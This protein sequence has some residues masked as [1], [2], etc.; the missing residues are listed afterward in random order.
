MKTA[1]LCDAHSDHLQIAQPGLCDF[2]GRRA[3]NGVIH[4]VKTFEDNSLV[5]KA[6]ESPGEGAV[7]VVDGGASKRCALLGDMLAELG[8]KNGWSG[9]IINGC[10]RDSADIASMD[11]GVEALAT[12][13]LKSFKRGLGDAN[14]PVT[15]LGVTFRPG[16][17]LYADADGVIVSRERIA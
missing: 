9:V 15:F 8:V 3:F 5:R 12:H 14:V 17:F 10:I 16:E 11:I 13:P 2:G 4:T 6:L 1:D 7:L